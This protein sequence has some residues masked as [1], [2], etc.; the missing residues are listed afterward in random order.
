MGK[1]KTAETM[2]LNYLESCI[3]ISGKIEIN[4]KQLL[5]IYYWYKLVELAQVKREAMSK[6]AKRTDT[7]QTEIVDA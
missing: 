7:N 1:I 5:E 3:D 6:H 4:R 2:M